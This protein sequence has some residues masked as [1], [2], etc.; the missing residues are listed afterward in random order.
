[1][2]KTDKNAGADNS[3]LYLVELLELNNLCE[4]MFQNMF[5]ISFVLSKVRCDSQDVTTLSDIVLQIIVRTYS[6]HAYTLVTKNIL[7]L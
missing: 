1:M 3:K 2:Q 5:S 6:T 4:D 7:Y